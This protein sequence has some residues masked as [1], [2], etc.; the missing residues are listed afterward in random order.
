MKCDKY[1]GC[2]LLS[3]CAPQAYFRFDPAAQERF[4]Q[5]WRELENGVLR[6]AEH[7]ML[8]EHL[9]KYRSLMPS[10][11]FHLINVADDLA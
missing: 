9:A 8:L 7:P 10:L 6:R 1:I 11:A 4:F 3:F 2:D 5:W